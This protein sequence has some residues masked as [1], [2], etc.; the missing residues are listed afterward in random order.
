VEICGRA[1]RCDR[2]AL[3]PRPETEE[4]LELLLKTTWPPGSRILDVGTG[5]GIIALTLAAEL[6]RSEVHAVDISDDAL[7]LAAENASALDLQGRVVF[8]RSDLLAALAGSFDLIVANLPYVAERDRPTLS[9]EVRHD[10]PLALFGGEDGQDIIR[11]LISTAPAHLKPGG[12]LA[13]EIGIGQA[14]ALT[15]FLAE[16]NYHDISARQDYAGVTRFLFAR[17]G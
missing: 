12:M 15:A 9:R 16:A 4:L 11:R 6:P 1:F 5:S 2:R 7:A 8:S 3:V 14:E 17:Y 10:P 13:L